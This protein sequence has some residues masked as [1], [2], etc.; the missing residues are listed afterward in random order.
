MRESIGPRI[1]VLVAC[2]LAVAACGGGT[3]KS[4]GAGAVGGSIV[5]AAQNEP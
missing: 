2:T 4:E 1:S 3:K 5:I